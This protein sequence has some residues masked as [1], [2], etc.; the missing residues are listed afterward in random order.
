MTITID[1]TVVP[2]TCHLLMAAGIKREDRFSASW[3]S[4]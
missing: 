1:R 2:R 4:H 3:G